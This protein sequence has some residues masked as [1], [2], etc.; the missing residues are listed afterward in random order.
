MSEDKYSKIQ[1][2]IEQSITPYINL[3]ISMP[4]DLD[5]EAFIKLE[6]DADFYESVL[7]LVRKHIQIMKESDEKITES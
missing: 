2:K 7:D 5:K 3:K 4:D 1:S 6:N